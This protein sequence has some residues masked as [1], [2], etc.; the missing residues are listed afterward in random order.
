MTNKYMN[1]LKEKSFYIMLL[2]S[3]VVVTVLLV[4]VSFN[5]KPNVVEK[6]ELDMNAPPRV[7]NDVKDPVKKPNVLENDTEIPAKD[8]TNVVGNSELGDNF[9]IVKEG[10]EENV[11]PEKDTKGETKETFIPYNG[12]KDMLWPI[13]GEIVFNYS[14][15]DLLYDTTLEKFTTNNKICIEAKEN[16]E[17]LVA[18]SGQVESIISDEFLG[19]SVVID[20]GDGWKTTYG[21][22][23]KDLNV[24]LNQQVKKGDQLGVVSAP[25]IFSKNLGFHLDFMVMKDGEYKDPNEYLSK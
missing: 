23:E 2:A 18:A 25:T 15:K 9:L 20:H 19:T 17:V 13:S 11:Q 7:T 16:Q 14:M 6:E 5:R 8:V 1:R 21:Q 3:I 4:I 10:Q 12:S 24:E 22:L